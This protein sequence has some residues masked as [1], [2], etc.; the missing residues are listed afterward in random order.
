VFDRL[1]LI[2]NQ[3]AFDPNLR[4]S[5]R[6][7]R[8]V[9]RHLAD[10]SLGIA[11]LGIGKERLLKNLNACGVFFESMCE[12]NLDIYSRSLGAKLFRYRDDSGMEV[13]SIVE[14]PDGRWGAFEIKLGAGR[15]DEAAENLLKFRSRM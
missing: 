1:F 8:T 15:I 13:D 11:T 10:P 9:K 7:G 4:S 12:R 3:P 2:D 14:M 6:V 5:V